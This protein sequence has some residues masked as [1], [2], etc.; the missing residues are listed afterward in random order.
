MRLSADQTRTE[1]ADWLPEAGREVLGQQ[2]QALTYG[3]GERGPTV[4]HRD[5]Q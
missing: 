4:Q 5:S 1:R 3:V 2:I